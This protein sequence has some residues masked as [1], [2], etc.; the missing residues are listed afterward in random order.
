MDLLQQQGLRLGG[1]QLPGGLAAGG[2]SLP[3][4]FSVGQQPVE[5]LAVPLLQQP[6]QGLRAVV[7]DIAQIGRLRVCRQFP[8]LPQPPPCQPQG[9]FGI[10]IHPQVF[11]P[12]PVV[13]RRG[14]GIVPEAVVVGV[15]AAGDGVVKM[16]VGAVLVHILPVFREDQPCGVPHR[17]REGHIQL[18]G[19]FPGKAAQSP[20]ALA[21]HLQEE[22]VQLPAVHEGEAAPIGD[23]VMHPQPFQPGAVIEGIVADAAQGGRQGHILQPAVV[24]L[25][26]RRRA[27]GNADRLPLRGGTV[28][29]EGMVLQLRHRQAADRLRQHG[30]FVRRQRAQDD[31]AVLFLPDGQQ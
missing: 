7:A 23:G 31:D 30:G 19:E 1:V 22:S 13:I 29:H 10:V 20:G 16:V 18:P 17:I 12:H 8:R 4:E 21:G 9:R 24:R 25:A 14:E 6:V 27:A 3:G 15:A 5:T 26:L 28:G 11:S 2:Q